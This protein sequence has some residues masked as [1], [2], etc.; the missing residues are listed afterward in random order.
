MELA[1]ARSARPRT[2]ANCYLDLQVKRTTLSDSVP[3]VPVQIPVPQMLE[4]PG[5]GSTT[6]TQPV[7]FQMFFQQPQFV[8][9]IV[10]QKFSI[11]TGKTAMI[12][13][14]KEQ[15]E[16]RSEYGAPVLSKIPY[17]NRL[18]KN[19]AYGRE[20]CTTILLVTPRI[21]INNETSEVALPQDYSR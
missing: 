4:G 2:D 8:T 13:A 20:S 11:P 19:V 1:F 10:D 5:K 14:G 21:I 17:M 9:Q 15:R 16:N 7:I 18:F 6:L 3:L 12:V